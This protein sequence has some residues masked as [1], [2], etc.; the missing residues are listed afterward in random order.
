[1]DPSTE[2]LIRDYLNRL[3]VAA[4]D[5]G[6]DERMAFLARMHDSI[7]RVAGPQSKMS[8]AEV[9]SLLAELGEPSGLVDAERARL[10]ARPEP[11][12][13]ASPGRSDAA[14]PGRLRQTRQTR[15][16]RAGRPVPRAR[17]PEVSAGGYCDS[18]ASRGAMQ[19]SAATRDPSAPGRVLR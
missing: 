7:E 3:A 12:P 14:A 9:A 11:G 19:D 2:Q 5:L 10:A 18:P 16:I 17:P 4:R 6:T 1:M 13:A 15:Q 8:P